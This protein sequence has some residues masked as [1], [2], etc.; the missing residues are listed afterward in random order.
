MKEQWKPIEGY[1]ELY[2]VSNHGRVKSK[3]RTVACGTGIKQA[4]GRII[5]PQDNTKG[6]KYVVLHKNGK[7]ENAYI[8]RL[9][10]LHFIPREEGKDTINHL[11]HKRDNNN[12]KNLE[13]T[14]Q[15]EN[16]R[17]S[18]ELMKKPRPCFRTNTG[19]FYI[20][21]AT[22]RKGFRVRVAGVE[23]YAKTM[24]IAL[25]MRAQMMEVMRDGEVNHV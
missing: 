17:W 21:K 22:K 7:R 19:E 25:A 16:V 13:W 23:R 10:A 9:V 8:H 15:K 14:T 6:Y 3:D 11:D 1:E 20:S 18:A 12:V 24:E 4:K 2:E 5:K